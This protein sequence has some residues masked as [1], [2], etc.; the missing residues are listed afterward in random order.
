MKALLWLIC[1][2]A[3]YVLLALTVES[4][5]AV[6]IGTIVW[7]VASF[8]WLGLRTGEPPEFDDGMSVFGEDDYASSDM[9]MN[10]SPAA[11][12]LARSQDRG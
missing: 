4:G 10:A 12:A 2:I 3:C 5:V 8:R 9:D 11:R 7:G 1:L 6:M